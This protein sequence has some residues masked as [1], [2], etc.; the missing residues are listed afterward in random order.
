VAPDRLQ[1]IIAGIN[2]KSSRGIENLCRIRDRHLDSRADLDGLDL[3]RKPDIARK[4]RIGVAPMLFR[5]RPLPIRR[6]AGDPRLGF[7]VLHA[8]SAGG[9]RPPV[10]A[11][12]AHV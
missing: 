11:K 2:P 12:D 6:L 10:T 8:I 4:D 9:V 7:R 5:L 3:S 1:L